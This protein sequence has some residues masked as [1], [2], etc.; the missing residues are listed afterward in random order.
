[1]NKH[2]TRIIPVDDHPLVREWLTNLIHQQPDLVVYGE[3]ETAAALQMIA[4]SKPEVAIVDIS[5]KDSL[6][7]ELIKTSKRPILSHTKGNP[8]IEISL[9]TKGSGH[10]CRQNLTSLRL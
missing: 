9:T 4:E 6:G 10:S 7:I 1:M 8:D 5:L 3:A 2:K